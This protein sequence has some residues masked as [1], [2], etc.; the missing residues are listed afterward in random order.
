MD[1]SSIELHR[2][3]KNG[4]IG[5]LTPRGP[6][7]GSNAAQKSFRL[8]FVAEA[9]ASGQKEKSIGAMHACRQNTVESMRTKVSA[10]TMPSRLTPRPIRFLGGKG[11]F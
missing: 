9:N 1:K 10:Q 11:A 6:A 7:H 4:S 5:F 3:W 2:A 8:E